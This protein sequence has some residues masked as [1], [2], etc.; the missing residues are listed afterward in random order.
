MA[1]KLDTIDKKI[2]LVLLKNGRILLTELSK[3]INHPYP[4]VRN[5]VHKLME[6]GIIRHFYP[7]LQY[8]GIGARRYMSIYITLKNITKEKQQE[9]IK[10]L[11]KN[12]YLIEVSELQGKWNISLLLVTNYL[13]E[14]YETLNFIQDLCGE[15]L[16]DLI[17]M[18]TYTISN[19]NRQ[20]FTDLE[21]D[22]KN[23]KTGYYSL[24]QK[25]PLV[26]LNGKVKLSKEDIQL[27]DYIKLNGRDTLEEIGKEVKIPSTLV[28]YKLKKYI[29][30]N[31]VKYFTIEIGPSKLGY[32]QYLLFLNLR[33]NSEAKENL[34]KDLHNIKEA[35]HYFEYLN[36]WEIV[37]TFIVKN[38]EEMYKIFNNLQNKYSS[39]IKDHEI[40]WLINKHKVEPYPNVKKMNPNNE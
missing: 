21:V 36:Y 24:I 5:R 7:V 8:P 11:S 38:R 31:L 39:F 33:G 6:K 12:P 18:P 10:K 17:V 22:I 9:I 27:L 35:Y 1:L 16:T 26:H 13:K 37:V 40:L 25:T 20:F 2:L 4:T 30:D 19:L 15:Y 23:S 29:S 28:D 32:E 34:I 3:I 14:C